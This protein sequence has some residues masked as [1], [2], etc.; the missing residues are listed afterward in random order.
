MNKPLCASA[1]I[2]AVL[3]AL[4]LMAGKALHAQEASAIQLDSAS[5]ES[6][7]RFGVSYCM[8]FNITA[9]FKNLGSFAPQGHFVPPGAQ[10]AGIQ[11]G[12]PGPA[13]GSAVNRTYQDGYNRKDISGN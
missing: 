5:S 4:G 3:I 13:T 9:Q 1:R 2:A 12:D 7:N 6:P 11:T 8:G 10:S